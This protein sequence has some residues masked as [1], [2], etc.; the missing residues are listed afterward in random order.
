MEML[1]SMQAELFAWRTETGTV[2]LSQEFGGNSE[3]IRLNE[4]HTLR[5]LRRT[6]KVHSGY[7]PSSRKKC[8]NPEMGIKLFNHSQGNSGG[9]RDSLCDGECECFR[10]RVSARRER[11][12][13]LLSPPSHP[14]WQIA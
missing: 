5:N 14:N 12:Q 9:K 1:H 10:H 13:R 4:R 7:F 8:L 3:H 2:K 11:W 6:N